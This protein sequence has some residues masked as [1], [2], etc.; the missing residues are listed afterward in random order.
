MYGTKMKSWNKSKTGCLEVSF[1][2]S[3]G[4]SFH[5]FVISFMNSAYNTGIEHFIMGPN[6]YV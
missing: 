5:P 3:G 4:E 6:I 2:N 1:F